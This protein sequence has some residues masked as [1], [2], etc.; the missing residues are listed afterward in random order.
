MVRFSPYGAPQYVALL[1]IGIVSDE[2]YG[3]AVLQMINVH[4]ANGIAQV[5]KCCSHRRLLS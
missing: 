4:T 3:F 2:N 5:L 1:C